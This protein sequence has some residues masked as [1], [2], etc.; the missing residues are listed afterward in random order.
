[1][2][3]G[4]GLRFVVAKL[5]P[6][7]KPITPDAQLVVSTDQFEAEGATGAMVQEHWIPQ[8]TNKTRVP[9]DRVTMD[10]DLGDRRQRWLPSG[11]TASQETF[12]S[13]RPLSQV[14][15]FPERYRC[16]Q[17]LMEDHSNAPGHTRHLSGASRNLCLDEDGESL[18]DTTQWGYQAIFSQGEF[19]P[20]RRAISKTNRC[21]SVQ[22]V[23]APRLWSRASTIRQSPSRLPH[24]ASC[25]ILRHGVNIKMVKLPYTSISAISTPWSFLKPRTR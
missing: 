25:H 4:D 6:Q 18:G 10:D 9:L 15:L 16:R 2:N 8:R 24:L 19:G 14:G 17:L 23:S 3:G 12:R 20:E 7:P 11:W 5:G 13:T 22:Q 1:M 21:P